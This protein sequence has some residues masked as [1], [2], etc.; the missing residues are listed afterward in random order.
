MKILKVVISESYRR[1]EQ[2]LIQDCNKNIKPLSIVEIRALFSI[3]SNIQN[4][5]EEEES[6]TFRKFVKITYDL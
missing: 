3:L 1:L 4:K 6:F 5:F 2:F